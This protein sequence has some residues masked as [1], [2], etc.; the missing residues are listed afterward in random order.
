MKRWD[1][2]AG[3]AGGLL[4]ALGLVVRSDTTV[5]LALVQRLAELRTFWLTPIMRAFT[6]LGDN[7][8]LAG[9]VVMLAV[10]DPPGRFRVLAVYLLNVVLNPA[11]KAAFGRP[12][13]Q[14]DPLVTVHLLS[15]P[16]GHAMAAAC[17]YGYAAVVARRRGRPGLSASLLLLPLL[18]GLSRV[19]LGVHYPTDVLGGY[20]AGLGLL[21]AVL[22]WKGPRRE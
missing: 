15:Y 13:P 7:L 22:A 3:M 19:Y 2:A 21:G 12:R 5:D 1:V 17:I 20:L 11:L 4:V 10:W 14:V 8:T 16:S 6:L 9:V 18:V